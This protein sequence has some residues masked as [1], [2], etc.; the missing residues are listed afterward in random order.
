MIIQ[1]SLQSYLEAGILLDYEDRTICLKSVL[2]S[3][4][5]SDIADT[6]LYLSAISADYFV[7]L[8]FVP[9]A[10][11]VAA[12]RFLHLASGLSRESTKPRLL[13]VF[14]CLKPS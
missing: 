8:R 3:M 2:C 5:S 10:Y 14:F 7:A 1:P 6:Y 13:L 11:H 4:F 9:W 12:L